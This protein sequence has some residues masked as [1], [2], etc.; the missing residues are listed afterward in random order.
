VNA[1]VLGTVLPIGVL[2]M[3]P[4]ASDDVDKLVN[5]P[6]VAV[7]LVAEMFVAGLGFVTETIKPS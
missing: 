6:V 2:L 7:T 5:E 3:L 1:P 4:S